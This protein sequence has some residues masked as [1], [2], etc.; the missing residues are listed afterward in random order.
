MATS[1]LFRFSMQAIMVALF[2]L[3][4]AAGLFG[5]Q[6]PAL[7]IAPIM[8]WT[9]WWGG[10]V[11]LI[12]FAGKAWCY[13]CPWDAVAG[14]MEKLRFWKKNNDGLGLNLKWPKVARNVLIA[15]ILFI[16]LTWIELGFG[17][18]MK[19]R[20]TSYLAIAMLLMAIASAFLFER[21]GFCR[22]ACLVG[23]VSGLYAMFSGVEVRNKSDSVCKSCRGKRM[24]NGK[25]N[26]L[27]LPHVSLPRQT[28]RKTLT[29]FNAPNAYKPAPKTT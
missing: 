18:T 4:I 8:T 14:W 21:K 2:F 3:I 27:R 13:V 1:R 15:T 11:L 24:R 9:V 17:V 23:R 19:P 10:L 26:G 28:H 29:A 25:R 6:N 16:G 22:Y 7:N 20:V 12:M 5:N